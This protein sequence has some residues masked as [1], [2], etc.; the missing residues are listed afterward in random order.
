[1]DALGQVVSFWTPI[2]HRIVPETTGHAKALIERDSVINALQPEE[3]D[4]KEKGN[5]N[6]NF[7]VEIRLLCETDSLQ[8]P[9]IT[10][11]VF[12]RIVPHSFYLLELLS[13]T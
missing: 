8:A 2:N 6:I 7:R 9:P 5:V 4:R 12:V 1:M 11:F 10:V 13:R 3:S